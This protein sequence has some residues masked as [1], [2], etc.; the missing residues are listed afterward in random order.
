MVNR[1]N[2]WRRGNGVKEWSGKEMKERTRN[3]CSW[4]RCSAKSKRPCWLESTRHTRSICWLNV[5]VSVSLGSVR[6]NI[7]WGAYAVPLPLVNL[8]KINQMQRRGSPK[9]EE[10]KY[11][12]C[13]R[14]IHLHHWLTEVQTFYRF[15]SF[16]W[17]YLSWVYTL[18]CHVVVPCRP[19]KASNLTE[20]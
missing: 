20:T 15:F 6:L 2:E 8:T 3:S 17:I 10:N 4:T 16:D 19:M 11:D 5:L 7:D 1:V 13:R 18:Y 12:I 9:T 14:E